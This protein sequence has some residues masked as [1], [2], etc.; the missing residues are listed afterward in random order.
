MHMYSVKWV[1]DCGVWSVKCNVRVGKC[2]VW[3]KECGV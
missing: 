2:G 1:G 3:S